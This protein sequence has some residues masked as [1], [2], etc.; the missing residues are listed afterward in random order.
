M[1]TITKRAIRPTPIMRVWATGRVPLGFTPV[2]AAIAATTTARPSHTNQFMLPVCTRCAPCGLMRISM[3]KTKSPARAEAVPFPRASPGVESS[4]D[5]QRRA[6][7]GS[8][9]TTRTVDICKRRIRI[10]TA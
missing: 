9:K 6:T 7:I 8:A 10:L 3:D 4:R 1:T 5:V 2:T